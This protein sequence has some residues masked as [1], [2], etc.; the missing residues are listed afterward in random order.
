MAENSPD[1]VRIEESHNCGE[2]D[3]VDRSSGANGR[4]RAVGIA[5][6]DED[7]SGENSSQQL[8]PQELERHFQEIGSRRGAYST[9]EGS[10][11]ERHFW[12]TSGSAG[13]AW[14]A[15]RIRTEL[16]LDVLTGAAN[17]LADIGAP[18]VD[19]ILDE[20]ESPHSSEQAFALLKALEWIEVKDADEARIGRISNLLRRFLS[21]ADPDVRES[22]IAATRILP[23]ASALAL[24]RERLPYERDHVVAQSVQEA[25]SEREAI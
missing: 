14:L 3:S 8:P 16:D 23:K 2:S 15:T 11:C 19:P 13:A 18:A 9:A 20:L 22:A 17:R 4:E 10:R 21:D 24:L 6:S 5:V 25:I 7:A 1:R 12:K